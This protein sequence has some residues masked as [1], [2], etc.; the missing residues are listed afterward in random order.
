MKGEHRLPT[1]RVDS[2]DFVEVQVTILGLPEGV[3][4]QRYRFCCGT[5]QYTVMLESD[6]RL[7]TLAMHLAPGQYSVETPD[8]Y[9]AGTPWRCEQ[10]APLRL[11][12]ASIILQ[13]SLCGAFH[14][15]L[16][17]WPDHLAHG[18]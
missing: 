5:Y 12:K 18:G 11:L 4:P 10:D 16:K 14:C 17:G 2:H 9:V 3:S 8:V 1:D 7:Q 15:R 6:A 13:L